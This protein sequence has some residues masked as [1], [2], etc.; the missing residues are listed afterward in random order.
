[1]NKLNLEPY[2]NKETLE[3]TAL[4]PKCVPQITISTVRFKVLNLIT[5]L[6]ACKLT[7]YLCFLHVQFLHAEGFV[8]QSSSTYFFSK[9]SFFSKASSL[10]FSE[11]LENLA[12]GLSIGSIFYILSKYA[13]P[14]ASLVLI[15]SG[16]W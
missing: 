15:F 8:V 10:T 2:K 4:T 3:R 6:N 12:K 13:S 1:M 16:V 14:K 5:F 7:L 11:F 9:K